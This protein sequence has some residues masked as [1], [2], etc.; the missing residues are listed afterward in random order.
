MTSGE[1][2]SGPTPGQNTGD[3]QT[4][5]ALPAPKVVR[6]VAAPPAR[7]KVLVVAPHPDDEAIGPG[8]TLAAHAKAGDEI[9]ALFVTSGVHG[10]D[11]ADEDPEAY[12]AERRHEAEASAAVLGIGKTEF[13]GYPD[14]MVVTAGDLSAVTDRLSG[15]LAETRPD[16]IYAPHA[17]E[18]H[19][20]HHFVALAVQRAWR[21][22]GCRGRLYGYEVWS[23]LDADIAVDVAD[24]YPLKLDA[25]R[26]YATQ[27]ERNDIPRAV[28]GLNRF[29]AVL[30]PPGGQWAEVF[31]EYA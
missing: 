2:S 12:V 17:G 15:L 4:S 21:A 31:E 16:V 25:I 6:P 1:P 5:P 30:L 13:W 29:R 10:G 3:A 11:A 28:D 27:L 19:S 14:S 7:G 22:Q 23:P 9:H 26:C 18:Q 8:A 20:D 24:T